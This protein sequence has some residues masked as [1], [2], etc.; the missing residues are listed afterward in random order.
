MK[1]LIAIGIAVLLICVGLSGC[2]E[3]GNINWKDSQ[4]YSIEGKWNTGETDSYGM[5]IYNFHNGQVISEF[6]EQESSNIRTYSEGEYTVTGNK[7]SF[8]LQIKMYSYIT[9]NTV[10]Y[11][12]I[13]Q[14]DYEIT[15]AEYG[16][17]LILTDTTGA[18]T[19]HRL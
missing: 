18:I 16:E 4:V 5:N 14:F 17:I 6:E 11:G 3:D 13:H 9:G 8:S 10:E 2:N 19:W 12:D 1:H 15:F 7:L